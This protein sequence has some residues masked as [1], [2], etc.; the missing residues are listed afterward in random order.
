MSVKS[1]QD[2]TVLFSTADASTGAA[3]DAD[4]TPTGTLYVNGTANGATMTV[5]NITT[6]LYKAAL[7]LPSLTAGDV[8]SLRVA[9]TVDSI[10]AEAVVWQEVADT[11]RVSDLND[12]DAAGVRTAVGL[13]AA[14][15]DTQIGTLA[16]GAS[17]AALN[18]L[19]ADDVWDE[20]IAAHLGIGSTGAALNAAGAAGDP[21]ASLLPAAYG[22]GTAGNIVG[23]IIAR[24]WAYASRTLTQS[25]ASVAEAVQGSTLTIHRGDTVTA[26]LTGLGSLADYVS[27]DFTVKSK[28]SDD[29][30]S[31]VVRIRLNATGLGDGLLRINAAEAGTPGNG[32]ITIDDLAAGDVT[33]TL[34]ADETEGLTPHVGYFYDIQMITATAVETLT[35]GTCNVTADVTRAVV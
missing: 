27:L 26:T 15:L 5:T 19:S 34:A 17:I 28:R 11:E 21:W 16:T 4:S 25:A 8:V 22:A 7:T 12:L 1:G 24:V 9:A 18:D 23:N 2:I 30:D 10:A 6:G 14:N 20:L 3:T 29:D 35:A 31:A 33:L 32:S 13:A